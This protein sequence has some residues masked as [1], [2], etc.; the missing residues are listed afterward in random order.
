MNG[1]MNPTMTG[2]RTGV[3]MMIMVKILE[4]GVIMTDPTNKVILIKAGIGGMMI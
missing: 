2:I 1:I 3:T 4:T